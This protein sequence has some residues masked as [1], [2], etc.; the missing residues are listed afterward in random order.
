MEWCRSRLWSSEQAF[1]NMTRVSAVTLW[2]SESLRKVSRGQNLLTS[3]GKRKAIWG[4]GR[5]VKTYR[6]T[7]GP[8]KPILWPSYDSILSM[9]GLLGC[10][11]LWQLPT[12]GVSKTELGRQA[13]ISVEEHQGTPD[14]GQL[15]MLQLVF[16]AGSS[17]HLQH[18]VYLRFPVDEGQPLE[19]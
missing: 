16:R 8:N 10:L 9:T 15:K 18:R 13:D 12:E 7:E 1:A 14:S 17:S 11:F 3:C 4:W 2:Q 5:Q 6:D 19:L